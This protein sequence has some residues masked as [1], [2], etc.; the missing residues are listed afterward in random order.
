MEA[1]HFFEISEQIYYV[2]SCNDT[3]ICHLANTTVI[4]LKTHTSF[5]ALSIVA[6]KIPELLEYEHIS[7]H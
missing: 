2:A 6:T 7:L 1:A 5:G 3:Y 4:S